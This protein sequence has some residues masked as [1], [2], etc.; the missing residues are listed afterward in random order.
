MFPMRLESGVEYVV[1]FDPVTRQ[2]RIVPA[3]SLEGA[4]LGLLAALQTM[5]VA[6]ADAAGRQAWHDCWPRYACPFPDGDWRGC[7]WLSAWDDEEQRDMREQAE[8]DA[9]WFHW[10]SAAAKAG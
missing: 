7:V 5:E 9:R 10:A 6:K 4:R 8:R 2:A 1:R 3:A